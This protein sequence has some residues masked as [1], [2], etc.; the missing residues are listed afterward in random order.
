MVKD[1]SLPGTFGEILQ[2]HISTNSVEQFMGYREMSI[3][4]FK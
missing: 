1:L 4:G 2:Y 3:H